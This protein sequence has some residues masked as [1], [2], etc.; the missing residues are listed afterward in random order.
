MLKVS[1]GLGPGRGGWSEAVGWIL[2]AERLGVDSAWTA[3]AW[4]QDAYYHRPDSAIKFK[5]GT[6]FPYSLANAVPNSY[7]K[8]GSEFVWKNDK[9]HVIYGYLVVDEYQKLKI[10]EGK[11]NGSYK[12]Y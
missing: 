6:Y 5:D 1:I 3:E 4:G 7:D 11:Y 8:V 12:Y 2:E 10:Q 9:P